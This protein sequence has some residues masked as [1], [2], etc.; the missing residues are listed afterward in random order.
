SEF[1]ESNKSE[2]KERDRDRQKDREQVREKAKELEKK[3]EKKKKATSESQENDIKLYNLVKKNHYLVRW[4][5]VS[6]FD[7][8][9]KSEFSSSFFKFNENYYYEVGD[10]DY[11]PLGD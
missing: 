3:K 8:Q 2:E 10:V 7:D 1:L 6:S 4:E 11:T 5:N 9:K